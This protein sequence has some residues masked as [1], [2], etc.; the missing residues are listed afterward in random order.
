MW[1][2]HAIFDSLPSAKDTI[3]RLRGVVL[4][5]N[6]LKIYLLAA[7][8]HERKFSPDSFRHLPLHAAPLLASAT[9]LS[10]TVRLMA[11]SGLQEL[12]QREA[13]YHRRSISKMHRLELHAHVCLVC[14]CRGGCRNCPPFCRR[15]KSRVAVSFLSREIS[16]RRNIST[17]HDNTPENEMG[18]EGW[19]GRR[20]SPC[21]FWQDTGVRGD[22]KFWGHGPLRARETDL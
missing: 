22:R 17:N 19:T 15:G 1:E 5:R 6:E 21:R 13:G 14:F 8:E 11:R 12:A 18:S 7:D 10:W 3:H 20:A 4:N 9:V 16:V 2:I